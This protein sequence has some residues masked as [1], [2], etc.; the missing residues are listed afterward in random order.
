MPRQV[1]CLTELASRSVIGVRTLLVC[2]YRKLVAA[3]T[4]VQLLRGIIMAVVLSTCEQS[5]FGPA[6]GHIERERE[7]FTTSIQ[8]AMAILINMQL[9]HTSVSQ[10]VTLKLSNHLG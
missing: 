1:Y 4:A 3:V 2:A 9:C 6:A 10:S 5:H 8:P 7:R